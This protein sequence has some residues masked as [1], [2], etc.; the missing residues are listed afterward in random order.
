MGEKRAVDISGQFITELNA[1][2]E[3][4]KITKTITEKEFKERKFPLRYNPNSLSEWE[5][6]KYEWSEGEIRKFY[7][8]PENVSRTI[9]CPSVN[10]DDTDDWGIFGTTEAFIYIEKLNYKGNKT[11]AD[12]ASSLGLSIKIDPKT[13]LGVLGH[14]DYFPRHKFECCKIKKSE[15]PEIFT[16]MC[17]IFTKKEIKN[18]PSPLL[19]K[20]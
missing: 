6:Q 17:D 3:A 2:D 9:Y 19:L 7:E 8:D 14:G 15:Y 10:V 13:G 1:I 11:L 20:K 18:P 12:Q 4:S 16:L 5:H